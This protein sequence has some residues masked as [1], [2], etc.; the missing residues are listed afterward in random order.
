VR[1]LYFQR[2]RGQNSLGKTGVERV[3]G[4]DSLAT[5][6]AF[7]FLED[8]RARVRCARLL[9][10]PFGPCLAVREQFTVEEGGVGGQE[11]LLMGTP[12]GLV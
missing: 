11:E 12:E 5:K 9:C 7:A 3:S 8:V 6:A 2:E 1:S 10:E 4:E